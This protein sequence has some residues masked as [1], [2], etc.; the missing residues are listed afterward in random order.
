ME[1]ESIKDDNNVTA[2]TFSHAS[3]AHIENANM[4]FTSEK[5]DKLD[6]LVGT[7]KNLKINNAEHYESNTEITS[8]SQGNLTRNPET[9]T[10]TINGN[11]KQK[12][13]S[14][15]TIPFLL[16]SC[17][18]RKTRGLTKRLQRLN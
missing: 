16:L 17:S 3:S 18:F 5:I 1:E 9:V 15:S 7:V 12:I 11:D 4:I 2:D 10:H 8:A 14:Y 6:K 13:L